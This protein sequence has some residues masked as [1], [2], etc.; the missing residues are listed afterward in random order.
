MDVGESTLAFPKNFGRKPAKPIERAVPGHASIRGWQADGLR[1]GTG[2][3]RIFQHRTW[4][5]T[6]NKKEHTCG[7]ETAAINRANREKTGRLPAA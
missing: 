5:G 6:K 3:A 4:T 7:T 1:A 2:R